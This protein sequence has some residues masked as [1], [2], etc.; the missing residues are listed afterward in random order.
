[1]KI[2]KAKLK[3]IIM[4]ELS[5][6]SEK[7]VEEDPKAALEDIYFESEF[8]RMIKEDFLTGYLAPRQN[9]IVV[10]LKGAIYDYLE[11]LGDAILQEDGHSDVPSARR[12]LK[13]TVEDA[14]E[15]LQGL[16][17]MQDEGELPS[18]WMGKVTLAAD[19]LNKARDYILVSG[20]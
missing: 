6:L 20:E 3:Q 10:G 1:M 11:G 8:L 5:S 7:R 4:E 2:T 12:K 9:E 16:E 15:I 13:T 19:Y 14:A 18:W 17:Q